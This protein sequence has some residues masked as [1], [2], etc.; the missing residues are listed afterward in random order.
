MDPQL[1]DLIFIGG[2][3]AVI[4]IVI[5]ILNLIKNKEKNGKK[6]FL[7]GIFLDPCNREYH[8]RCYEKN[9]PVTYIAHIN[10]TTI[11]SGYSSKLEE[12][13]QNYAILTLSKHGK[14]TKAEIYLHDLSDILSFS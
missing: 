7:F 12:G 1:Y 9:K 6:H 8:L 13:D 2:I 5:F 4:F 11:L 3:V 10:N 14:V